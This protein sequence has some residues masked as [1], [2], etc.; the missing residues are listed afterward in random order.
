A[1]QIKKH[2]WFADLKWDD[3]SQKKLVPPFVPNLMSPTDL[4]HFDESFIAMTPRI[5]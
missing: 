1:E 2:A 5:S 4:T 3:V